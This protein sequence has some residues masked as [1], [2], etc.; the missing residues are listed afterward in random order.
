MILLDANLLLYAV[1]EDGVHHKKVKI[2]LEA[3]FSRSETI[4]FSRKRHPGFSE[5]D[6]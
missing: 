2:W 6:D 5:I 4:G 1:N 3:Q